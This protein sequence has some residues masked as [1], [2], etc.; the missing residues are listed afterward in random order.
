MT[1]L[2]TLHMKITVN[3]LNFP[4]VTHTAHSDTQFGRY[5]LLNSGYD[6]DQIL[7]RLDIEMKTQL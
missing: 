3:E 2:K 6:A 4:L 7:D 5:G 1:S